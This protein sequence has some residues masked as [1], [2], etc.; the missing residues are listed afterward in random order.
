MRSIKTKFTITF[1]SAVFLIIIVFSAAIY[2][3]NVV[4]P[5][6][7]VDDQLTMIV[8]SRPGMMHFIEQSDD[9]N[10]LRLIGE[11]LRQNETDRYNQT[12]LIIIPPTLIIA[13]LFSYAVASYLVR[14]IEDVTRNISLINSTNLSKRIPFVESSQEIEI[15]TQSFNSLLDELEQAF[16]AQEQFIQDAAHEL[17]TPIATIKSNLEVFDQLKKKGKKDYEQLIKIVSNL[18]QKLETLNEKLLF[19][20]RKGKGTTEF[21]KVNINDI[22]EDTYEVLVVFAKEKNVI[23]KLNFKDNPIFANISPADFS[24]AIKNLVENAIKYSKSNGGKVEIIT[25]KV[26]SGIQIKITDNGLGIKSDETERIFDRFF[27]G[28]NVSESGEGLGLSIVKKIIDDHKGTIKVTS[29]LNK[30]TT[31]TI[32]LPKNNK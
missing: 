23:I 1:T 28:A 2:A 25:A 21:R 16:N 26:D 19:L 14:P 5:V 12:L 9:W 18:N 13:A 3:F 31:F 11:D 15:L 32:S 20:N 6:R 4:A 29:K 22:I 10:D 17:R 30:G 24:L 27:R 8:E 7:P